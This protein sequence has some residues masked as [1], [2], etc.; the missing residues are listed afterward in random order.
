M[1]G[2]RTLSPAPQRPETLGHG[3]FKVREIGEGS[4]GHAVLVKDRDGHQYVMKIIDMGQMDRKQRQDAINEVK[5]L[6]SLKHPYIISY[7]ESFTEHRNLAIVMDY[8]DGGDLHKR[9]QKTRIAGKFF[10]EGQVLRWF[11][12]ASL[13]LKYMHDKH[14]LHRD[15]KSQNLFLTR[16]DRLRI[17]DFGISKVLEGTRAFA[18]T[19]IG[20]PYYL[21]PEICM[22][23]PYS[24]SS[25]IWALGCVLYELGALKVPFDAT[26]LH[27][28]VHKITHGQTPR[29]PGIY[30]L[31]MRQLCTDLLQ[32]EQDRR[33]SASEILQR[34]V[35]Q[36]EI[37]KMLREEQVKACAAA[38]PLSSQSCASH[39]N[40]N[41]D[42][43]LAM[44]HVRS[45]ASV[46]RHSH[47]SEEQSQ[48]SH[49]GGNGPLRVDAPVVSARGGHH[50]LQGAG[51]MA[52]AGARSRDPSI[53]ARSRDPSPCRPANHYGSHHSTPAG[54]R[55][56]SKQ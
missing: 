15:F 44:G 50:A 28:L 32:R 37:R 1:D 3:Y 43:Y 12:E 48:P 54:S 2:S 6:A 30:S 23:Q 33:P 53:G 5:V 51:A 42:S 13:A 29:M 35:I 31:D 16:L 22:D 40:S 9:I 49:R 47:E 7:R 55:S 41:S 52:L 19:R 34:Q 18:Q 24:Y 14:V 46:D 27:A 39:R 26:N 45:G 10:V 4:Y 20:T 17:G 21:S 25:D 56:S 11:T 38:S 8:A 36:N